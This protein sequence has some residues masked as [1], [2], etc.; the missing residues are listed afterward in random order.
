VL[1]E[2]ARTDG[3]SGRYDLALAGFVEANELLAAVDDWRRAHG[4]LRC[5]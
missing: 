4:R 2:L 5:A 1:C 3:W